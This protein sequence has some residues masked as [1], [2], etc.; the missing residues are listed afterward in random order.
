MAKRTPSGSNKKKSA[1]SLAPPSLPRRLDGYFQKLGWK[2]ESVGHK[3]VFTTYDLAQTLKTKLDRVAKTLL[4]KTEN[5][6]VLVV[7]PGHRSLDFSKLRKALKVKRVTLAS[8]RDMVEKLKVKAG[9]LTPFGAFHQLPTVVDRTLAKGKDM[10]AST[11]NFAV[12]VRIRVRD[13]LKHEQPTVADVG[14]PSGQ[15]LQVKVR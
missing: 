12:S 10:I 15:K 1:P 6:H 8:E 14:K 3:T 13:F 7:L 4:V 9:T 11:G 2:H 5:G